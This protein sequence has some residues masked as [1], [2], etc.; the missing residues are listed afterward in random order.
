MKNKLKNDNK[1]I[2]EQCW[3]ASYVMELHNLITK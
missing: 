3:V 2:N 1:I